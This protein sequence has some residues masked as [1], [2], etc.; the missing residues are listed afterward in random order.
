MDYNK[1]K[2]LQNRHNLSNQKMADIAGM[3]RAQSYA[4]MMKRESMK[5]EY[6]EKYAEYFKVDINSFFDNGISA[7]TK[8]KL[9]HITQE[10]TKEYNKECKDCSYKDEIIALLKHRVTYFEHLINDYL[11]NIKEAT[12]T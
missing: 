9:F 3:K 7:N 2:S 5:V 10:P 6:L 1:V 12:G 4:D 11:S 8:D